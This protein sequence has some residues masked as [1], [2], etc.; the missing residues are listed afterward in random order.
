M[1]QIKKYFQKKIRKKPLFGILLLIA[2]S[3]CSPQINVINIKDAK[4]SEIEDNVFFYFLPKTTIKVEVEAEK[5]DFIAGPYAKF[6]EKLLGI[7]N[8]DTTNHSEWKINDLQIS[9][10]SSPDTSQIYLIVSKKKS[11]ANKI[12]LS[13]DGLIKSINSENNTENFTRSNDVFL[14]ETIEKKVYFTKLSNTENFFE[15]TLNSYKTIKTDSSFIRVPVSKTEIHQKTDEQKAEEV[16]KLILKLREEK[17]ALLIGEYDIF[18][19]GAAMSAIIN[20]LNSLEKDYIS[21]FTGYTISNAGTQKRVYE[22]CPNSAFE[23][24]RLLFKF[25]SK[26]GILEPNSNNGKEV[27]IALEAIQCNEIFEDYYFKQDTLVEQNNGL[28]YRFPATT[29]VK[30]SYEQKVIASAKLLVSQFGAV[31]KLPSYLLYENKSKIEFYPKF[32][33]LKSIK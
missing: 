7:K 26:D 4:I 8:I 6:A 32:G 16:V 3:G 27:K 20:E 11:I 31:C 2:F 28:F 5:T 1:N 12:N 14:D 17:I 21:L 22:I 30:I 19:E 18:P 10:F 13:E 9:D 33:S 25:S 29:K 23:N 24:E 15:K